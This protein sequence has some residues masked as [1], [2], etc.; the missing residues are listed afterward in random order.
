MA[1]RL[2]ALRTAVPLRVAFLV[3]LAGRHEVVAVR[4]ALPLFVAARRLAADTAQPT[5][6]LGVLRTPLPMGAEGSDG[7]MAAGTSPAQ[8]VAGSDG[9][10]DAAFGT[11]RQAWTLSQ[12][13]SG[14]AVVTQPLT[15]AIVVTTL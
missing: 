4:E 12:R 9:T 5:R 1:C 3:R 14:Q 8:G 7:G 2:R 11:I 10:V 15:H 13:M 6:L